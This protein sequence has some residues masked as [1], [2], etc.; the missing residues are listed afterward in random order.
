MMYTAR[1]RRALIRRPAPRPLSWVELMG[2]I[3]LV[4][5]AAAGMTAIAL[6]GAF[7]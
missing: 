5:L 4:G 3:L 1:H 7:F 6:A 2:A